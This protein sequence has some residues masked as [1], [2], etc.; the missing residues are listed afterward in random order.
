MKNDSQIIDEPFLHCRKPRLQVLD[1]VGLDANGWDSLA[2]YSQVHIN[3]FHELLCG[4]PL[5]PRRIL[6]WGSG[7]STR[8]LCR[9]AVQWD[10]KFFLTIDHNAEYQK[11]ILAN[12]DYPFLCARSISLIGGIWPWDEPES[13]YATYPLDRASEPYDFIFVD[14]RRRNECLLAA[15]DLLSTGGIIVLHDVWRPRY[16]LGRALFKETGRL[17]QYAIMRHR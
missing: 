12:L 2:T 6:E 13:N 5:N 1:L 7:Y 10:T 9:F 17:D 4:L 14:G 15:R 11:S 3:E 8:M 16:R